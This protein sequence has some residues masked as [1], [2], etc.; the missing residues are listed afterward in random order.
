MACSTGARRVLPWPMTRAV[1][2][3]K[4]FGSTRSISTRH[5]H[6]SGYRAQISAHDRGSEIAGARTS[7][8]LIV[9]SSCAGPGCQVFRPDSPRA[10]PRRQHRSVN[11]DDAAPARRGSCSL[12][13]EHDHG[14]PEVA[15]LGGADP[16]HVLAGR[17]LA[18]ATRLMPVRDVRGARCGDRHRVTGAGC[19]RAGCLRRGQIATHRS[20]G[21]CP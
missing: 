20:R 1:R 6:S 18:C 4:P 13:V 16:E 8:A 5:T 15:A 10:R 3:S 17:L 9:S 21:T 12:R 7:A 11:V 2:N 14:R 19:G